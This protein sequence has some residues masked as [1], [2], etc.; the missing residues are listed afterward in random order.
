M[1][2]QADTERHHRAL[3]ETDQRE[4]APR[5][6]V[7]LELGVEKG[8]ERRGGIGDAAHH[9]AG[10]A[11]GE[12]EPLPA[13]GRHAASLGRMRRDEGGMGQELRPFTPQADEVVAVGAIAMQE[14]DELARRI[15]RRRRKP[16]SVD[17]RQ[18]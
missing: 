18:A 15:A 14:H 8:I 4:G 2:F 7:P 13:H 17:Q 12:V 10:I 9:L 3:A 1:A 16:R 6:V 11:E 5:Q